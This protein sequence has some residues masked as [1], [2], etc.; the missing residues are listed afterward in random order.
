MAKL[1]VH[2]LSMFARPPTIEPTPRKAAPRT[3]M[4]PCHCGHTR[5]TCGLTST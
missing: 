5:R 1:R 3:G 4:A 2:N